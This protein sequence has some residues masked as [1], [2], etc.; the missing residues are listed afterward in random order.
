MVKNKLQT[1]THKEKEKADAAVCVRCA[2]A[3]KPES[4]YRNKGVRS[5]QECLNVPVECSLVRGAS[6]YL[7]TVHCDV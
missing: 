5:C 2:L 3:G 4:C 6:V 1:A 7:S